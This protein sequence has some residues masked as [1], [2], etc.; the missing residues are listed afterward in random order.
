[1]G[2]DRGAYDAIDDFYAAYDRLD[3]READ[4]TYPGHGPPFTAYRDVLA[5]S[6]EALDD[7]LTDVRGAVADVGPASPLEVT[8]ARVDRLDHPA[9]LLDT[10]GALGTLG[11]RDDVT[12]EWHDGVR[13]YRTV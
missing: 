3:A 11:R 8:R 12:F 13:Q 7:L 10:L 9:P 4:W 2:L 1:V 5:N 6:R